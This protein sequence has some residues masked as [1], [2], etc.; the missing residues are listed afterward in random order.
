MRALLCFL[1]LSL[2]LQISGRDLNLHRHQFFIGPEWNHL[3]RIKKEGTKQQGNLF[4][5]RAGYDRL[6]RYGWYWGLEGGCVT[7]SLRGH[8]G[9][10]SPLHSDFTSSFI[11]GRFGYTFQQKACY[12]M[13]FTPF[14]GVGYALEQNHFKNPSPLPLHFRTYFPYGV[15]GF[16]SWMHLCGPWDI[17]LNFKM[18]MPFEPHC[19]VTHDPDNEPS[20]QMVGE[21][22][23]YRVDLPITWHTPY[24]ERLN[25]VVN[26]FWEYRHYGSRIN[27]PFDFLKTEF[28][29]WGLTLELQYWL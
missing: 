19:R 28:T 29:T 20:T 12:Q 22:L 15:W 26:P 9:K 14:V 25:M 6:K 3:E 23:F 24:C 1:L 7:G 27:Y 11:E 10:G 8:S 4:G 17:G 18:K 5:L 2:P 13:A 21:R 16:L